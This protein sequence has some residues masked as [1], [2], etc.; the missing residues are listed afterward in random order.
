[1]D[2]HQETFETWNKLASLYQDK[3]MELHLY[4]ETYDAFCQLVTTPNAKILDIACGPGNISRY[5]LNKRPDF[6][7]T[8]IDTAENMVAL[9]RKNNPSA[10]FAVMDMREIG[11]FSETFD[12]IIC[13]FGLPYLSEADAA[14]LFSDAHRL[15]NDKG[16]VYISFV[17]GAPA[18]SGFK[19]DNEGNRIY[20]WF[21]RL[22]TILQQLN[23]AGFELQKTFEVPYK[24][25]ETETNTDIHT[26]LIAQKKTTA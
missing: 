9:A 25:N 21:H 3:F 8:G 4:D 5:L 17:D 10:E 24:T 22:D 23:D 20:F 7:L 11:T 12:G 1:M 14:K 6:R 16:V 15:L 19:A 18:Q 2:A 26:I 13:G